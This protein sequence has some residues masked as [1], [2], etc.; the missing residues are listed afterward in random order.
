MYKYLPFEYTFSTRI[1]TKA[2][3]ISWLIIFPVF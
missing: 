1:K 2:E 3:R